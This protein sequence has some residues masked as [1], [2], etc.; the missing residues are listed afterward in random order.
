MVVVLSVSLSSWEV[1]FRSSNMNIV[2]F[3]AT[4]L[5]P[6]I[7]EAFLFVIVP[8]EP[9]KVQKVKKVRKKFF[10][11]INLTLHFRRLMKGL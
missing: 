11:P 3:T 4:S 5:S 6:L 2:C 1:T 10:S 9:H 7:G 8:K